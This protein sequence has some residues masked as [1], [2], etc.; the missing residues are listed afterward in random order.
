MNT[1][2]CPNCGTPHTPDS[3]FCTNCGYIL[4]TP[5]PAPAPKPVKPP[6]AKKNRRTAG[7]SI[8]CV[9]MSLLIVLSMGLLTVRNVTNQETLGNAVQDML[10]DVDLTQIPAS[11]IMANAEEGQSMA[12]Y[13]AREIERSYV[14]EVHV[15]EEDVQTFLENSDFMPFIAEKFGNYVDDIRNDRRGKGIS[16][17]ELSELMWD[18]RYDIEKLVGIPLTQTDV[19]NVI[20]KMNQQGM[21]RD[22]RAG[23]LK[24]TAPEGYAALQ[25]ALSDVTIAVLAAV[26][27]ILALLI[28][29]GYGWNICRAC[30]SVGM[31]M[32]ISG[33]VFLILGLTGLGLKL[34]VNSLLTYL[35]GVVLQGGLTFSV[36]IFVLGAVLVAVDQVT[37]RSSQNA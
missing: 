1:L 8:L 31:T 29:M 12:E 34:A 37:R 7:I 24:S 23:T 14:I 33:G 26:L 9:L 6:K 2:F 3:R 22:L 18:N 5:K 17:Q 11:E 21:M 19:N 36:V 32:L 4:A 15:D 28:A 25:I 10:L 30:G 16:E 27:V 35:I 20:Q 13:I